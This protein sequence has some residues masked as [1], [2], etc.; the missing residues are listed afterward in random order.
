MEATRLWRTLPP[1]LLEK[2][3]AT[4]FHPMRSST[5]RR[6]A[7]TR[8]F[9]RACSRLNRIASISDLF[10]ELFL[11]VLIDADC[12]TTLNRDLQI[13]VRGRLRVRVFCIE[14]PHFEKFR[15]PNLKRVRSTEISLIKQKQFFFPC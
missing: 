11:L 12:S 6:L 3:Y 14:H 2:T 15:P 7:R 9:S 5:N 1:G 4:V 10:I 8:P 13:G